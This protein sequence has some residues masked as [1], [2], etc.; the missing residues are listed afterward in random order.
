[1]PAAAPAKNSPAKPKL[2]AEQRKAARLAD[3][4]RQAAEKEQRHLAFEAQRPLHWAQVFNKALRIAAIQ[5][6]YPAVVE[7][8][9]WWFQDFDVDP[10]ALSFSCEELGGRSHPVTESRL[11][12]SD[13][14]RL[15]HR[16]DMALAWFDEHDAEM[17]RQ[18]LAA[19]EREQRKRKAISKLDDD[20]LDAL[21]LKHLR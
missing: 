2:T 16:L 18:R 5:V 4:Q 11:H 20:D 7:D 8:N 17:E 12:A 9:S 14:E 1:M 10:R 6:S 21:G 3:A 15:H 19:I 13:I